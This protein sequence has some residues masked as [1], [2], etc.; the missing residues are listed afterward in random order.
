MFVQPVVLLQFEMKKEHR[1][2]ERESSSIVKILTDQFFQVLI[3]VSRRNDLIE[4]TY[5]SFK[6]HKH[7][8]LFGSKVGNNTT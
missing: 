2:A 5:N 7:R 4:T 1:K 6:V 3:K 8:S